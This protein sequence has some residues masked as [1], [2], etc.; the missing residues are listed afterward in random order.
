[1]V[2]YAAHSTCSRAMQEISHGCTGMHPQWCILGSLG[3]SNIVHHRAGDPAGVDQVP[4]C[5]PEVHGSALF[6][7]RNL[8][9]FSAALLTEMWADVSQ[10]YI[11]LHPDNLS[12][13]ISLTQCIKDIKGDILCKTHFSGD[14]YNTHHCTLYSK[15][16]CLALSFFEAQ[17]PLALVYF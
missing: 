14:N 12:P 7:Q 6:I 16:G 4:T 2:T 1:M 13:I 8:V 9:A 3:V 11:S 17:L 5:T 15:V 10:L